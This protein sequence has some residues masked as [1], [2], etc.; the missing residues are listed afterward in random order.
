M[1]SNIRSTSS[2]D[3]AMV[4][5]QRRDAIEIG[6]SQRQRR[7]AVDYG[8]LERQRTLTAPYPA[9]HV[10]PSRGQRAIVHR[11]IPPR[12]MQPPPA[13]STPPTHWRSGNDPNPMHPDDCPECRGDLIVMDARLKTGKAPFFTRED[14]F[15]GPALG[16]PNLVPFGH[17]TPHGAIFPLVDDI[18]QFRDCI[19]LPGALLVEHRAGPMKVTLQ[20][21]GI[22][23]AEITLFANCQHRYITTFN[24]AWWL[25]RRLCI[26][27]E[28]GLQRTTAG[29]ELFRI[30]FY[31]LLVPGKL[32]DANKKITVPWKISGSAE[33]T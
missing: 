17:T 13:P 6:H 30:N 33:G 31:L 7:N 29:L 10:T 18:L 32:R 26:F 22:H 14:E 15:R 12:A 27:V 23:S 21:D 20:I 19:P 9:H 2:P 8:S 24:L 1:Y 28:H 4:S 16:G 3:R 25:A 11:Q 5:P